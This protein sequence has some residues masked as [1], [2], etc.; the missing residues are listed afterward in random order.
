MDRI[1]W[2][3]V[4]GSK[5]TYLVWSSELC[6]W[7]GWTKLTWH[8]CRGWKYIEFS[9]GLKL[10]WFW[11]V[12]TGLGFVSGHRNWF[13]FRAAIEIDLISVL[14]SKLTWIL[15][16]GSKLTWFECGDQSWLGRFSAG[17]SLF[18]CARRKWLGFSVWMEIFLVSVAMEIDLFSVFR[19]KMTWF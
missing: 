16:R 3:S 12:E 10:T 15:C 8:Q 18:L 11:R 13:H 14:E 9:A 17:R 1:C 7:C 19:P 2:S 5:M 4:C 6:F